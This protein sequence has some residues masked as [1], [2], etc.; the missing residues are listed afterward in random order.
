M[1]LQLENKVYMLAGASKGL[2]LATAQALAGEGARVSIASRDA[3]AIAA[4]ADQLAAAGAQVMAVACDVTDAGSIAQWH[5]QTRQ[6]WGGVDGVLVNAGGPTPGDFDSLNDAAWQGAFELTLLSAVRLIRQVL[7]DLRASQAGAILTLTSCSV[8]EPMD[9]LLL[10]NVMRSGVTSLAKSLSRQL[11]PDNVRV[12]NLMPGFVATDRITQLT[13]AQ[14]ERAGVAE[15]EQKRRMEAAIPLGRFGDT[16][17]FGRIAAF[18]LSPAASYITGQ[19]LA[20]DGGL[21]K[22][23]W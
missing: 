20:A 8:K 2:G 17:E 9:N 5:Q 23:V 1:D 14:A 11:A 10:S 18:L 15:E 4:A 3:R 16:E 22:T 12:N 13:R 6:C 21:L 19:T 7:P